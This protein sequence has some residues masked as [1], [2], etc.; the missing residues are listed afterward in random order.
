[1][2]TCLTRRSLKSK[3]SQ[4]SSARLQYARKCDVRPTLAV[5]STSQTTTA[6]RRSSKYT[7]AHNLPIWRSTGTTDVAKPRRNKKRSFLFL[8]RSFARYTHFV[9]HRLLQRNCPPEVRP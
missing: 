9:R 6:D 1:M 2:R 7:N 4:Q 3:F 5:A 8:L